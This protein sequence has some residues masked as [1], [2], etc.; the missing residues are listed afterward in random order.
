[1]T[2][3]T[4][5]QANQRA[6]DLR[7]RILEGDTSVTAA[8]LAEAELEVTRADLFAEGEANRATA[9]AKAQAKAEHEARTLEA[10]A[11]LDPRPAEILRQY[12]EAWAAVS[13]LREEIDGYADA[14]H[15]HRGTLNAP[16]QPDGGVCG[17]APLYRDELM[18]E[19]LD[20]PAEQV[21]AL[22]RRCGENADNAADALR[23]GRG[24]VLVEEPV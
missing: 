5:A 17:H 24:P 16:P 4:V 21:I 10:H 11:D 14:I 8:M 2:I 19:L 1:M 7:R 22:L 18:R 12:R 3:M 23:S 9:E 20:G 6:G 15:A 13:G